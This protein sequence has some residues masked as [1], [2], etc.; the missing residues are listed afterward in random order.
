MR[1][2]ERERESLS[3]NGNFQRHLILTTQ[4]YN[5]LFCD[6]MGNWFSHLK[7]RYKEGKLLIAKIEK[8]FFVFVKNIS[9]PVKL[10]AVWRFFFSLYILPYKNS[11]LKEEKNSKLEIKK[12]KN[13]FIIRN[14]V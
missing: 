5:S 11:T 9:V 3:L 7:Y 8:T 12:K 10:I 13:A 2:R 1:G 14:S 4:S 6:E